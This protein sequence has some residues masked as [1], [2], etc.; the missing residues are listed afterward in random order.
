MHPFWL[1][2]AVLVLSPFAGRLY[3]V[4]RRQRRE[5]LA[6]ARKRNLKFS[7]VDL[8]G[9]HD[10]Y[11]NLDLIRQGHGRHAW[12]VLY[13]SVETGLIAVF[14]Y[15]Y[16][17]GFGVQRTSSQWWMAV[18]ESPT[19]FANWRAEPAHDAPADT[20]GST[21]AAEA[22]GPAQPTSEIRVGPLLL[23]AD[24]AATLTDLARPPVAAAL[25]AMPEG[26]HVEAHGPL[27]ALACPADDNLEHPERLIDALTTLAEATTRPTGG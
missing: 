18:L 8:I 12:N 6:L 25:L 19:P 21:D 11:Y 13:G 26:C 3:L 22:T 1:I 14:R 10:R 24:R 20:T 5:L 2:A 17:L 16:D 9:L 15:S 7:P 23:H 27:L 4:R